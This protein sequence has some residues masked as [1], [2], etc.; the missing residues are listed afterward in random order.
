MHYK[1]M[2]AEIIE[3]VAHA[4]HALW[5]PVISRS[6]GRSGFEPARFDGCN[7]WYRTKEAVRGSN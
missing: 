6:P 5:H 7:D 3:D 4:Q 2:G 1:A